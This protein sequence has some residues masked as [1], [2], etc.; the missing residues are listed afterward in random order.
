MER[1]LLIRSHR[2]GD[3]VQI[4]PLLGALRRTHPDAE[5]HVLLAEEFS[6]VLNNHPW[7]DRTHAIPKASLIRKRG[8]GRKGLLKQIE[9]LRP[10]IG[11]LTS[12][13]FSWVINRQATALE[14]VLAG[15]IGAERTSGPHY[16]RR[17]DAIVLDP[18]T[19]AF[20][21]Q[22]VQDRKGIR[23]NLVDLSFEVAGIEIAGDRLH[24]PVDENLRESIAAQARPNGSETV[25]IGLQ[26][27]ASRA[28][29]VWPSEYYLE[30]ATL[31]LEDPRVRIVIFGSSLERRTGDILLR[32]L[33]SP[34]RV[35]RLEGKTPWEHLKAWLAECDVLVTPDTG[36]M[37]VAAAVGT[38]VVAAFW[39]SAH[40]YETGPYGPNH[41]VLL[42]ELQCAPCT[43]A[44]AC[45]HLSCRK[46]IRPEHVARAVVLSLQSRGIELA[47]PT[48]PLEAEEPEH[49]NPHVAFLTTGGEPWRGPF[50]LQPLREP[51][52]ATAA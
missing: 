39:G 44:D 26:A 37:H 14:T 7:V 29:R 41:I 30:L 5:I 16:D 8:K 22:L 52:K 12:L 50:S 35:L 42:A 1:I 9:D 10:L 33:S 20:R 45:P 17:Q 23:T 48:T 47:V 40:P 18:A 32:G 27:G 36:P 19:R 24:L 49:G 4:T 25:L 3:I 51:R 43:S 38:P 21:E 46:M 13:H 6:H 2:L 15:L 34:H 31:L 28:P 11:D